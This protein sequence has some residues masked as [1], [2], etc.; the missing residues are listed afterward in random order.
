MILPSVVGRSI[1]VVRARLLRALSLLTRI[2]L[3]VCVGGAPGPMA[4]AQSVRDSGSATQSDPWG[5]YIREAAER[6]KMPEKWIRAVIRHESGGRSML[7]GQPIVSGEGAIGLMQ[8][9]PQT[10][11]CLRQRHGLG[12]DAFDPHDNILAGTAYMHELYDL[13]DAPG[14]L[15]AYNCGPGC[16]GDYLAG[17]RRLPAEVWSY[18]AVLSPSLKGAK[19]AAAAAPACASGK[20]AVLTPLAGLSAPD[21]TL[22]SNR[23]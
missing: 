11:Q 14:F 3:A 4:S 5:P 15:G 7:D 10:Y 1:L 21:I 16:Y 23:R 13:F 19:P 12:P 6:F 9:M 20:A 17:K 8:V 2:L 18:I 22:T